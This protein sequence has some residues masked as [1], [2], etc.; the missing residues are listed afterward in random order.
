[1]M[2]TYKHYILS[3]LFVVM[4][5]AIQAQQTAPAPVRDVIYTRHDGVALTMDV[6]RPVTP[7]GRGII[8]IV[9]GGWKSSHEGI[10]SGQPFVNRGYT[11]FYVV[12]GSQPRFTVEEIIQDIHQAVRFIR[13][14]AT[15]FGV[16]P[17]KLGITGS[18]AGGHLSLMV[19]T[20]GG[21]GNPA[22]KDSIDRVSSAVQAAAC[23][24]PPTDYLNW[25]EDGDVA[26]GVGK[27]A[28][29]AAAFGPKASTVEGRTKLGEDVSPIYGVKAGQ[30]PVFI[31][32]GDADPQVPVTQA[33][34]FRKRCEEVGVICEVK[35]VPG[36]GHGGWATMAQD[37]ELMVDWFDR[38]LRGH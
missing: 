12:H 32:H 36:G 4:T 9:S 38:Q 11:V 24:Y 29:Y 13:S 10:G 22:A 6:V 2:A 21:P 19:V 1:M 5:T 34:R 37:R 31:I 35:V 3:L 28:A 27:L 23:F 7:N 30:P 20:R 8:S 17:T 16:D 14:R 15:D 25:A 26:V 18:S 33:Y